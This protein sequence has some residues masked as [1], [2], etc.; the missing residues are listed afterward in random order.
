MILRL[1]YLLRVGDLV[2]VGAVK[3]VLLREVVGT[4]SVVDDEAR[5]DGAH[6]GKCGTASTLGLTG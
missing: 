3:D 4:V 1:G 2:V 5:L 6:A